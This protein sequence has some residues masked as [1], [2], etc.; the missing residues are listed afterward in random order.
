VHKIAEIFKEEGYP[1]PYGFKIEE[2]V[3]L[4]APRLFS[5]SYF[6]NFIHAMSRAGLNSH[7]ISLSTAVMKDITV[8]FREC[9]TETMN[10]YE[11]S[12]D[13]LLS[14][15]LYI[16]SPYLPKP[17]KVDFVKEQSFLTGFFG[18]KRP[19]TAPEITALYSNLQRNALGVATMIG[20][21]Q[22]SRDKEV[23]Q[24][25]MRGRDIAKKHCEV[26]AD[27]LKKSFL[28][29][30]M[31]W[32][33]DA[34]DST[35]YVFSDKLMMFLVISLISLSIQYY[36]QSIA[37]SQRRDLG[38]MYDRLVAE[39]QLYAEDG[40]NIMIKNGWLEEPPKAP[41]R[42]ELAKMNNES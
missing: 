29:A 42:D 12:K 41:D 34:T 23:T 14:K 8:F 4:T 7:S 9:V 37:G 33:S 21:S 22:V 30:P 5:D 3:D 19:L 38:L 26:F 28:P 6:L 25:L 35:Q 40:A 11:M 2:D 31:T 10:L 13:V 36:G 24:F 18:E 15:G 16:R 1:I 32:D 17:D 39:I 20:F 27:T